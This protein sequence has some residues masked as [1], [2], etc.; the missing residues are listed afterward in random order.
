MPLAV[1]VS[2]TVPASM[3]AWFTVKV[4]WQVMASPEVASGV[5]VT[6][7]LVPPVQVTAPIVPRAGLVSVSVTPTLCNVTLPSLETRKV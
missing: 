6:E 1:A 2:V 3:P 5:R 7:P 4:A